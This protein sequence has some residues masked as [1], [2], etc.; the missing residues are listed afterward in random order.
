MSSSQ[1]SDLA[2][3][4]VLARYTNQAAQLPPQVRA[5]IE[6]QW[7]N[8]P[9]ILYAMG[10]L[11]RGLKLHREWVALGR[12]RIA[13]MGE[14][15]DGSL[16]LVADLPRARIKLVREVPALS[17]TVLTLLGDAN[18][19]ALATIRYSHRQ[20]R[21]FETIVFLLEQ[22]TKGFDVQPSDDADAVYRESLTQPIIEAQSAFARNKGAIVWRLV[23]YM[24]PYRRSVLT[25][26]VTAMAMTILTLL[27]P[28]LTG[29]LIDKVVKPF[30]AH[31][32]DLNA[33]RTSGWWYIAAIAIT[34][35]LQEVFSWIRLRT[36]SKL[37]ENVARDLRNEVYEHLQKLSLTYFSKKRTGSIISRVTS[38]T[39]RLWDF[40]AFGMVEVSLALI[41]IL[42]LAVV[43]L[44]LDWKLGLVMI[45]P[46][47]LVV[48]LIY[49]HGNV[50]QQYFLRIWR[51]WSNMTDIVSD[52]VP[53][54]RVVK[55][56]HQGEREAARFRRRNQAVLQ[57]A[58]NI[59]DLWTS[60]W[61]R[62]V[63]IIHGIVM[64]IWLIAMPRMITAEPTLTVGK[65]V[66]FVLYMTMFFQPIEVL[67]QV[68]RMLNRATSSAHRIFEVL[69]S[70][71][72]ITD[73]PTAVKLEP[74]QGR[75]EFENVTFSYDG[76]RQIIRGMSFAVKPG[77]MIGL[78]GPSGA[79]KSTVT[80]LIVRFYE[81]TGGC[82]RIDGVD[83][84]D[85]DTE[86]F[87]RQVGMVLQD[88]YLFHGTVL[89]NI[90]YSMPS[91]SLEEV[92]EAARIANVHDFVT[93]LPHGYDTIVGERGQT[94]SG[95]ERQRVAI[96]RAVLANPRIL[97]LDE[98]TSSV[99]TETEQKIQ[100]ALDR[101]V[102]GRTVFAIAHRLST[103]RKADRLFVIEEGRIAE[104][105]T[106]GALLEKKDGTYRKLHDMQTALH[107]MFAV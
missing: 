19:P 102:K 90:R 2:N 53:G 21:A 98:A 36:L 30:Q 4:E 44:T 82:I 59:H 107:E 64:L 20:R 72:Q 86:S 62:V 5:A 35:S 9:V 56:F 55:A 81:A 48:G 7:N 106:H 10:D 39:D 6:A 43:L 29:S 89:D 66:Q 103:L 73:A 17:C 24:K 41:K 67:G 47:P 94:L 51:K 57:E 33:A 38:D 85:L 70:K 63:M 88:S 23:G 11:D 18:E 31:A 28:L 3:D 13:I 32:L 76:V 78:V 61:P 83:V 77:E 96:A 99:D 97:I 45:A 50:I 65:F 71:P 68:G 52:T 93:K 69:D 1:Q 37:G 84:R 60:F 46:I 25:G 91:A 14:A 87:R 95:G 75:V 92:I 74:V 16:S 15:R 49:R 58:Y 8:A 40:V 12:E 105:G 104:E 100:E 34:L 54:I 26:M 27:P 42:A 22:Q 80:N 101:L 79:G